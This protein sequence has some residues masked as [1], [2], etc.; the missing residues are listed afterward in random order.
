MG[1]YREITPERLGE[2]ALGQEG[3]DPDL[4]CMKLEFISPQMQKEEMIAQQKLNKQF[5]DEPVNEPQTLAV[6][7]IPKTNLRIPFNWFDYDSDAAAFIK[8][9]ARCQNVGVHTLGKSRM[10]TSLCIFLDT[11]W[12][13]RHLR[14]KSENDPPSM[15]LQ[16]RRI[17]HWKA[18]IDESSLARGF[19]LRLVRH[20]I[21]MLVGACFDFARSNGRRIPSSALGDKIEKLC[22]WFKEN[23]PADLKAFEDFQPER[24][25]LPR[26]RGDGMSR[27]FFIVHAPICML[28]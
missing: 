17:R 8:G 21:L 16:E 28:E 12:R 9:V 15:G 1:W 24:R 10:G 20:V 11:V 6:F 25:K 5:V 14:M 13:H 3:H 4:H 18:I 27:V 22:Y 19:T 23:D 2:P 26:P 7:L